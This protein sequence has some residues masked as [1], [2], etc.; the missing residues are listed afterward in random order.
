MIDMR[1]VKRELKLAEWTRLIHECASSG[2]TIKAW[3]EENGIA[4]RKYNYWQRRVREE[5]VSSVVLS[6]ALVPGIGPANADPSAPVTFRP[7]APAFAKIPITTP[8][9]E[10]AV[11]VMSVSIGD[12]EVEIYEGADI[13]LEKTEASLLYQ[14]KPTLKCYRKES[15]DP[16]KIRDLFRE[17]VD[18]DKI[19]ETAVFNKLEADQK[20]L[21]ESGLQRSIDVAAHASGAADKFAGFCVNHIALHVEY[22]GDPALPP[23][24][25]ELKYSEIGYE[26]LNI[27]D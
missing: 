13:Y 11:L 24:V 26:N 20:S 2:K 23:Y 22:L 12:A 15:G 1:G 7:N 10:T 21:E 14:L 3:C 27:F 19:L 9:K 4:R 17:D 5:V 25:V 8:P 18:V 16:V 6:N